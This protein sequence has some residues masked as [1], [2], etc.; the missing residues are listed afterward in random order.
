[1]TFDFDNVEVLPDGVEG[2]LCYRIPPGVEPE[3]SPCFICGDEI[4]DPDERVIGV[5]D[6]GIAHTRCYDEWEHAA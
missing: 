5:P 1:M 6:E 3:A 4:G 2:V